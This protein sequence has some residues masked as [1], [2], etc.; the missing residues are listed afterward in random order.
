MARLPTEEMANL[1][2]PRVQQLLLQSFHDIIEQVIE[3]AKQQV[4]NKIRNAA[5]GIAATLAR[6]ITYEVSGQQLI[7]KVLFPEQMGKR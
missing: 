6:E 2:A 5:G 3:E 7:I 1:L 4:E